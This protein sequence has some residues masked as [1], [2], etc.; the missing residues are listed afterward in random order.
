MTG[1][2]RESIRCAINV[3]ESIWCGVA[4]RVYVIDIQT[5]EI[6]KQLQVH[7]RP[8]HSVQHITW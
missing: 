8:E 6:R 7:S 5:L 3:R 1:K 2:S 4:N